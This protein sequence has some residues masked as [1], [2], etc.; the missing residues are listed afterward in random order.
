MVDQKGKILEA[1]PLNLNP[2]NAAL[3]EAALSAIQS[4]QF[5]QVRGGKSDTAAKYFSFKVTRR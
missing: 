3:S 2:S 1:T 5:S 4:W